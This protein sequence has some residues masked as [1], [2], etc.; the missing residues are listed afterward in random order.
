MLNTYHRHHHHHYHLRDHH[1]HVV[2]SL[3]LVVSLP[4]I[5]SGMEVS[6]IDRKSHSFEVAEVE[7]GHAYIGDDDAD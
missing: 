7:V 6:Q 5:E 3:H 4:S 2:V 1:N